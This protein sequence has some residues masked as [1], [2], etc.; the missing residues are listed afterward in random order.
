ML[1]RTESFSTVSEA[2]LFPEL[3]DV[4][5]AH[6]LHVIALCSRHHQGRGLV[7]G[8]A[9]GAQ[10]D[11]RLRLLVALRPEETLELRNATDH[12]SVPDDRAIEVDIDLDHFRTNR[13]WR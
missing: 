1:A 8:T 9:I 3:R 6:F 10:V 13:R 4:H 5:E 2:W 7:T 11:F 12:G